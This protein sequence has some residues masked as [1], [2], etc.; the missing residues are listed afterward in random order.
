MNT[1]ILVFRDLDGTWFA[2]M[3]ESVLTCGTFV[4]RRISFVKGYT[5]AKLARIAVIKNIT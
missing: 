4:E 3:W 1:R 2:S 5:S